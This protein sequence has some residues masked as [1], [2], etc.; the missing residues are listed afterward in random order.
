MGRGYESRS[1]KINQSTG[2]IEQESSAD[3]YLRTQ[4]WYD[5]EGRVMKTEGS[6]IA[7]TR[8]DRLGRATHQW[9]IASDDDTSYGGAASST[10][11]WDTTTLRTNITGDLVVVESQTTYEADTGRTIMTATIERDFA[12]RGGSETTGAL[13]TNADTNAFKYTA[14]NLKGR[15]QISSMWYDDWDRVI[16]YAVQYGTNGGWNFDR[17]ALGHAS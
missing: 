11:V 8:Y 7:K 3:V 2:A 16:E 6:T 14:A 1:Y 12:D 13:D 15:I 5:P 10:A 17:D 4:T 9:R